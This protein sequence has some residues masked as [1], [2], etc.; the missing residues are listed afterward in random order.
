VNQ[1][2]ITY[3]E[4]SLASPTGHILMTLYGLFYC[5]S[6]GS[7]NKELTLLLLLLTGRQMATVFCRRFAH[8]SARVTPTT[9]EEKIFFV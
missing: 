3:L 2:R 8:F 6:A 9:T 4:A 1:E 7:Q 5:W